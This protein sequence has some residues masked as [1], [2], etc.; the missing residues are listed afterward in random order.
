MARDD[1]G[2]SN[3][4]APSYTVTPGYPP[5]QGK[6]KFLSPNLGNIFSH[7]PKIFLIAPQNFPTTS[8]HFAIGALKANMVYNGGNTARTTVVPDYYNT[9]ASVWGEDER[10]ADRKNVYNQVTPMGVT[11]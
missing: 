5:Y 9:A 3:Y 7:P 1:Y 11:Y 6:K 8:S 10:V 2:G 4:P